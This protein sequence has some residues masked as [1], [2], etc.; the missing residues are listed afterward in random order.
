MRARI[1][2]TTCSSS[3]QWGISRLRGGFLLAVASDRRELVDARF[4]VK[5]VDD[6]IALFGK[7][8]KGYAYGR[9][10]ERLCSF[11]RQRRAEDA[12][13]SVSPQ[14]ELGMSE[15]FPRNREVR[16]VTKRSRGNRL[17]QTS[18]QSHTSSDDAWRSCRRA[19]RAVTS[20]WEAGSRGTDHAMA[21]RNLDG[22]RTALLVSVSGSRPAQSV[23]PH[24]PGGL[25]CVS[26]SSRGRKWIARVDTPRL[27]VIYVR[28][29]RGE[30][31][32]AQAPSLVST[33]R[34]VR[35]SGQDL[36]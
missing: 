20:I 24:A 1:S 31:G 11:F 36:T 8:P 28:C 33:T 16:P 26:R 27:G 14:D 30:V 32:T 12:E 23:D 4:A 19:L 34:I 6:H 2:S 9:A 7:A 3:V 17:S 15:A 21:R 18:G 13:R 35:V 5:A 25:E 22:E 10:S 29:G